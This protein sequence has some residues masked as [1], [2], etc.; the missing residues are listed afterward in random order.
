MKMT[1]LPV[2]RVST[3]AEIRAAVR[4]RRAAGQRVAFVPT[5]GA[6]HDG[7]VALV[8]EAHRHADAVVVSIFV[9]PLQF[10]PAED[11]AKYPRTLDADVAALRTHDVALLFTPT[12]ETMY[13]PG[14]A[15]RVTIA[16]HDSEFEGAIRPE[17]F[18][19]VLTVVAKLLNIVQPDVA[20]FGQKDLQQLC[21]VR[22]MVRDMNVPIEIVDVVTV[23]ES[24]GL[25]MSSRNRYLSPDDRARAVRLSTALAAIRDRFARGESDPH[26]LIEAGRGVLAAD[27][28][29]VVDYLALVDTESFSSVERGAPGVAAILAARIGGTR[30]LDNIIL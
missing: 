30:L 13:P 26:R 28:Q 21:F 20:V 22:R 15:T 25:A 8:D 24:D 6:L 14:Q 16:P 11:L 23:R 7:H 9:N 1:Q 19:G 29:I 10:G 4:E 2:R 27:T 12:A 18:T 5:M 17:H 3:I